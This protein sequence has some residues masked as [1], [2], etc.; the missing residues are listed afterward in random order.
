MDWKPLRIGVFASSDS[1]MQA[2]LDAV[3]DYDMEFLIS[4]KSLD[5]AV[6][7][8]RRMVRHGVEAIIS[9][10]RT[11]DLL[12]RHLDLPV[13]S[14]PHFTV[15]LLASLKTAASYGSKVL[16][17]SYAE[18][19]MDLQVLSSIL[20][21]EIFQRPYKDKRSLMEAVAWGRRQGCTVVL[22]GSVTRRAAEAMGLHYVEI[23]TPQEELRAAIENARSVALSNR[24]YRTLASHYQGILDATSDGIV[25]VDTSGKISAAN[26]AARRILGAAAA[27]N[28][29]LAQVFASPRF[30]R[31]LGDGVPI[32]D[33]VEEISGQKYLV[34]RV[35]VRNGAEVVGAILLFKEVGGVLQAE[36]AVRRALARG[37]VAKYGFED[38]V[39]G[40]SRMRDVVEAARHFAA[41]DST[42]LLVGETGTGKE[43]FAHSI[44]G[45]SPRRKGPFV[46]V[47]CAALPEQLLESELFGYEEGAFTGS[48]KGGKAGR[49]E[50]AHKGTIFLDEIDTTPHR[51]QVR[52][53]RILQE[54]EVMR[55][56]GD[57]KIPIDVR[58][59]AASSRDLMEAVEEGSF[60]SDLFFR[61]NVLKIEIP[62]LRERREDILVLLEHF[63]EQTA[64][65]HRLSPVALPSHLLERLSA[66]SWPGNVRQL[67]NFAERLVLTWNLSLNNQNAESLVQELVGRLGASPPPEPAPREETSSLRSAAEAQKLQAERRLIEKA[68]SECRWNRSL[69]A[70]KLGISRTTLWRKAKQLGIPLN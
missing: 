14:L 31:A 38:M 54:R 10:R 65:K 17:P 24:A 8:G 56:G 63:I 2:V 70:R 15:E 51:V 21:I 5:D 64:A 60:R 39:F 34:S 41:T 18:T 66:Y 23:P 46:S 61:L 25:A 12:R 53:L 19:A 3:E 44:H 26:L 69:A 11:A 29:P 62:P 50:L 48:R 57:R 49:F 16:L 47:N 20:N 45:S 6:E 42:I 36:K 52:L 59:V 32:Q 33:Q 9:R 4:E 37:L 55:I 30:S 27:P 40:S 43:L 7:E 22:G 67:K 68:L 28:R 13:V 1:L 58:V 35:P